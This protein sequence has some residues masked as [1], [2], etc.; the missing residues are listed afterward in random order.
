MRKIYLLFLLL[1]VPNIK[2]RCLYEGG[3]DPAKNGDDCA[4][5]SITSEEIAERED[6]EVSNYLCCFIREKVGLNN[7]EYK[8]WT[9]CDPF[10]E[11]WIDP[12]LSVV[13]IFI[14]CKEPKNNAK[15]YLVTN[16]VLFLLFVLLF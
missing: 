6:T 13:G 16:K 9:Y 2:C 11:E 4:L 12:S 14:E 5:R 8:N 15:L 1:S 3:E 7:G 10:K